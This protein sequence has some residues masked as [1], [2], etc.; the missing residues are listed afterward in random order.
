MKNITP[1]I[2]LSAMITALCFGITYPANAGEMG[3]ESPNQIITSVDKDGVEKV[4]WSLSIRDPLAD[5]GMDSVAESLE[6][7]KNMGDTQDGAAYGPTSVFSGHSN[8]TDVEGEGELDIN[9]LGDWNVPDH[10]PYV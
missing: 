5:G 1:K 10:D 6:N 7:K 4:E 3:T 8:T 9:S 2:L